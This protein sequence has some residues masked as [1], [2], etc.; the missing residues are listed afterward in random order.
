MRSTAS[1]N[2]TWSIARRNEYTS[3]DSPHPKQW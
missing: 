1:V 2:E 3:P